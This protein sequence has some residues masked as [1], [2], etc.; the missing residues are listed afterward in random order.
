MIS[1]PI[2]RGAERTHR[3]GVQLVQPRAILESSLA[4]QRVN[5]GSQ[6]LELSRGGR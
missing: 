3:S 1:A 2:V 6:P 4:Q 5:P